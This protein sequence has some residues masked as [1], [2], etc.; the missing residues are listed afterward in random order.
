MM[1]RNQTGSATVLGIIVVLVL[2]TMSA[3]L[4][5]WVTNETRLASKSRDVLEAQYA[6]EA[7]AKRAVE[8]FL[9]MNSTQV[10]E[11]AWFEIEQSFYQNATNKRYTVFTYLEGDESKT[12]VKPVTTKSNTYVI[13]STGKVNEAVRIVS[14]SIPVTAG[15]GSGGLVSQN[16]NSPFYYTAYAEGNL[17]W[18]QTAAING[19]DYT[20]HGAVTGYNGGSARKASFPANP[21]LPDFATVTQLRDPSRPVLQPALTNGVYRPSM[22][23]NFENVTL[24]VNGNLEIGQNINFTNVTLFVTGTITFT[25]GGNNFNGTSFIVAEKSITAKELGNVSG[26]ILSYEN[27]KLQSLSN[28]HGSIVAKGNIDIERNTNITYSSDN[29]DRF[30]KSSGGRA[31][32]TVKPGSWKLN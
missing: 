2:I 5:P 9:E 28:L 30:I 19:R 14:V 20:A 25:S 32:A 4:L 12:P 13:Q 21:E 26:V 24:V 16:P 31:S 18:G 8:E 7:G 3:G 6:A 1:L 10:I 29:I 17:A 11:S 22:N 15:S 23:T 27:I